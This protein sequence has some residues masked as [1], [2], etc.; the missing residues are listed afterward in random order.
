[1]PRLIWQRD[2]YTF[3]AGDVAL[4]EKSRLWSPDGIKSRVL[5]EVT[6][7]RELWEVH[8]IT[9][10][11]NSGAGL[12]KRGVAIFLGIATESA[13]FLSRLATDP[14]DGMMGKESGVSYKG[15]PFVCTNGVGW[16]V[17]TPGYVA[18]DVMYTWILYRVLG[19]KYENV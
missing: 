12:N 1:M 16:F 10:T 7:S 3:S 18:T 13:A 6:S 14:D 5:G 2:T 11:L 4:N 9:C 8:R 15:P 17:R 19:A